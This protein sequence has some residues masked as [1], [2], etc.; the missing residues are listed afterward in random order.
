MSLHR[1]HPLPTLLH[2]LKTELSAAFSPGAVRLGRSPLALDVMGGIA[3]ETGSISASIPLER[4]AATAAVQQRDD[5]LL[6]IFSF[7]ELDAHRPFTLC[8][9]I[10]SLRETS[11]ESLQQ[12]LAEPGRRWAWSAI[13]AARELSLAG[14][15]DLHRGLNV[16]LLNSIPSHL[17]TFADASIAAASVMALLDGPL[18]AAVL[19]ELVRTVQLSM[20]SHACSLGEAVT[21]SSPFGAVINRWKAGV[22]QSLPSI[23]MPAGMRV[24][25]IDIN[26]QR[27]DAEAAMERTRAASAM[28][29]AL[30]LK[31]MRD[32]GTAAGRTLVADP[33]GGLLGQL[34]PNDYK[35]WF[36]TYLPEKLSG[37]EFLDIIGEADPRNWAL[38]ESTDYPVRGAADHHVLE[39]LRV[40]NFSRFL[41]EANAMSPGDPSRGI[42]LDKAGHLM[43]ASHQSLSDDAELGVEQADQLIRFVRQRERAGLYGARLTGSGAQGLVAVLCEENDRA[44]TGLA[45]VLMAYTEQ[46]SLPATTY[47]TAADPSA[48]AGG[49]T[50]SI[51]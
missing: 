4:L 5:A 35:R 13:G 28:A 46:T 47:R 15:L 36:R 24:V 1:L 17:V 49:E 22:D 14:R 45:E 19:A 39:S 27:A 12:G 33:I 23:A 48:V 40:R 26:A 8:L 3:A 25:A 7:D 31:K 10:R 38:T 21:A 34:D 51:E 18:P 30:I 43:Y 41:E 2:R 6:Q 29:H 42:I 50:T 11:I 9:P 37:T 20:L 32:M 16:A 44:T